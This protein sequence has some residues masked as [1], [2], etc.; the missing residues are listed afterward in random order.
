MLRFLLHIGT[1]LARR[2]IRAKVHS[3]G[4]PRPLAGAIAALV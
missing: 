2:L 4:L 3:L 1:F